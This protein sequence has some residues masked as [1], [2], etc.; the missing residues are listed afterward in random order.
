MGSKKKNIFN[1]VFLIAVFGFTI[2]SIFSG[3]DLGIIWKY[4]KTAQLRYLLLGV[5]CVVTFIWGESIIIYYMMRTLNHKVKAM[6]CYLY[7]FIGFFF[8][9]VTPSASGGQPAQIYYM[10]KDDIPIPVS[11]LVLMIVTITYKFVL[12]VIGLAVLIFKPAHVMTYLEPVKFWCYLGIALN[13]FCVIAMFTLVFHP[14]LAKFIMVKGLRLL[15]HLHLL[16]KKPSRM[17]KLT[18][19]M[20]QY[21]VTAS[22]FWSH[23]GVVFNAFLITVA[24]RVILFFVTYLTYKAF[25]LK[26]VGMV[27]IVC[28]QAMISVA[29]DMLPLPGGMGISEKLFL[30]IFLPIFGP[31]LTLPAMIVSRGI[32]Y[33]S[34]LMIS[35]IMTVVAHFRIGKN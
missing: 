14:S 11:T 3:K 17:E 35:A 18:R 12:V 28:C 23:M 27:D 7:S 24:Q 26:G 21:K 29:V 6:R 13:V 15:E 30:S 1:A 16:K 34:Q 31:T 8:S 19:S 5:A 9:C 20:E 10:K 4:T 25:G 22:F 32:S 2:W 33:Y